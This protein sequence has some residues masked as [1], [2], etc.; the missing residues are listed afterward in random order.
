MN[1]VIIGT[2]LNDLIERAPG[3]LGGGRTLS[4]AHLS[5][6]RDSHHKHFRLERST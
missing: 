2:S 6:R 3:K 5:G 1:P 4:L